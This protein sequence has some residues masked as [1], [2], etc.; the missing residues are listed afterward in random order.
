MPEGKIQFIYQFDDSSPR[1]EFTLPSDSS[2]DQVLESFEQFLR[3]A[4]YHFD[5][6]VD[7]LDTAEE[8]KND[9]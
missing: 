8:I 1:V 3:G 9:N 6:E 7:L 2:L 4:G 5:G